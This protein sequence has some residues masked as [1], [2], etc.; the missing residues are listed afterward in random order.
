MDSRRLWIIGIEVY[1]KLRLHLGHLGDLTRG[2][3]NA[4][5]S[6]RLSPS[7][8]KLRSVDTEGEKFWTKLSYSTSSSSYTTGGTGR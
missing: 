6:S 8:E 1:L 5:S 2:L 3:W 7:L 4:H